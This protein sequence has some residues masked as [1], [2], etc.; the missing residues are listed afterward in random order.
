MRE[1]H[2]YFAGVVVGGDQT[3]VDAAVR[4]AMSAEA[5]GAT[6]T[7]ARMAGEAEIRRHRAP[8]AT[9][10]WATTAG[11][12][13]PALFAP[14]LFAPPVRWGW[15]A[16]ATAE[17]AP[18]MPPPLNL[19]PPPVWADPPHPDTSGLYA[20]RAKAVRKVVV[21]GTLAVL[22]FLAFGVYQVTIEEQVSS[23]GRDAAQ[24]YGYVLPAAGLLMA[25]W[26]VSA[27]FEIR[28]TAADIHRFRRPYL[29][30]RAAG[31]QRHQHAVAEWEA[32]KRQHDQQVQAA[33]QGLVRQQAGPQWYPVH[34]AAEPTRVDIIGGDPDRYGW[35]C[36]LVMFGTSLLARGHRLTVLDLT[37][38]RAGSRLVRVAAARGLDTVEAALDD[39]TD[40]DLFAGLGPDEIAGTLAYVLTGRA[41]P[42]G[43]EQHHER[44]LATEVLGKVLSCL[45]YPATFA[46]LAAGLRVL[47]R[48]A[49]PEVLTPQ[50][51]ERL[52]GGIGDIDQNDWTARHLRLWAAELDVLHRVAPGGQRPLWTLWT[53]HALSVLATPG[54]NDDRKE[55]ID[56]LLVHLARRAIRSPGLRGSYL[57]VAGV[58][59]L[60]ATAVR[61]LSEEARAAGVRL[62]LFLDQ[63]QDD[64]E[65]IVGTGGAVCVMKMY[66]HKDATV[67]A[68][69]IGKGHKFVV[70]QL[71]HQSGRTFGDGGGDNFSATTGNGSTSGS[72]K[73]RGSSD[74]RG[75]TW[76][77]NRTWSS[78]ENISTSISTS[79]VYEFITDTQAILGMDPTEF[80]LVD[81]SG[82]GRRVVLA[83]CHP[84][85]C[86][87]D[88]VSGTPA[89]GRVAL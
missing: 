55:L 39:G 58:D 80:I 63:P 79:R 74:S 10:E 44:A 43:G 9:Q 71:T 88:R 25:L 6:E 67:A 21:R 61:A 19:G 35:A 51:V 33:R 54:G 87:F 8:A 1:W 32:A 81:N 75:H 48:A 30:M 65:K 38:Q 82:R 66:N 59:R 69:F 86:L 46:R 5:N 49:E 31:K 37:G 84:E 77:G 72:R 60:G 15:Q 2:R 45:E 20:K 57:A 14:R 13:W 47:R 11:A 26:V 64:L 52:I 53:R 36:L 7:Q 22:A 4:A 89:P 12:D 28:R 78:A 85:I 42:E 50:E 83:N 34:P 27:L 17:P 62:V 41:K 73:Q 16:A 3:Q 24:V 23:A 56:R 70:N 68:E 40:F 29:A 76:A 18:P